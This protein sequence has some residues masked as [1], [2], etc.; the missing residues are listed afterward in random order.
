MLGKYRYKGSSYVG[1][2]LWSDSDY[3]IERN[4]FLQDRGEGVIAVQDWSMAWS[5]VNHVSVPKKLFI[6]SFLRLALQDFI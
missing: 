2:S 5:S 6:I 4:S 1:T 3:Q